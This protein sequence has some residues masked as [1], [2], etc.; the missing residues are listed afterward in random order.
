MARLN[1]DGTFT[2][3]CP[4]CDREKSGINLVAAWAELTDHIRN[5]HP[6]YDPD[7]YKDE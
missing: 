4:R 2:L 7:W 6:E 3:Y 1:P 5:A